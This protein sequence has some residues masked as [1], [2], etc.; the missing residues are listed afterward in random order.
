MGTAVAKANHSARD[1]LRTPTSGTEMKGPDARLTLRAQRLPLSSFCDRVHGYDKLL[2]YLWSPR[3]MLVATDQGHH[4]YS[5]MRTATGLRT[6]LS[7]RLLVPI[8]K[9]TLSKNMRQRDVCS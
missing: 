8:S 6:R 9:V 4:E 1:L 7:S 2:Q 5:L 3:H